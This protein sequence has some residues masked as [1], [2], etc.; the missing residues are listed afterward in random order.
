MELLTAT[1]SAKS[2]VMDAL[3]GV[4]AVD[5]RS[6]AVLRI[7]LGLLIL[8]DLAVRATDLQAHYSDYGVLSR[9]YQAASTAHKLYFIS[10]EVWFQGLLFLIAA[11][12]AVALMLGYFTRLA[13]A[14]CWYFVIAIQAR[15]EVVLYGGDVVFRM[16]LFWGMFLPLGARWSL[17]AK[18]QAGRFAVSPDQNRVVTAATAAILLQTCIIYWTTAIFKNHP[19]WLSEGNAV[20]YA[21]QLDEFTTPL[22]RWLGQFPDMLRYL[23]RSTMVLEFFGPCIVLCPWRNGPV[24][25]G[26]VLA[27]FGL[28]LGFLMCMTLGIFPYASLLCWVPFIP[29]WFWDRVLKRRA[30]ESA[31][32]EQGKPARG[33]PPMA[34][35]QQAIVGLFL[36]YVILWNI[37]DVVPDHVSRFFPAKYDRVANIFRLDQHWAM[38]APHPLTDDGWFVMPARLRNGHEFDLWSGDDPVRW[39]KP[40]NVA[41]TFPNMRWRKYMRN[42]WTDSYAE[43]HRGLAMLHWRE[44]WNRS[45]PYDEQIDMIRLFYM[46]ETTPPPGQKPVVEKLLL[47]GVEYHD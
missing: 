15:N 11:A 38:F 4:F 8:G 10:G 29:G 9:A 21:L 6:L 18:R 35:G 32:A 42:I 7:G 20:Y 44:Q 28:H 37:R 25:M 12:F 43:P 47:Y 36:L 27:F 13:T 30:C 46:L 33:V 23:T 19:V 22:G 24:R 1:N 2:R 34:W 3:L 40:A 26:V 45:H 5:L 39:D 16:L 41:A 17:D 31:P 14:V